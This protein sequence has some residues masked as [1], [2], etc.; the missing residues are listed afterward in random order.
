MRQTAG[1]AFEVSGC[2]GIAHR[3]TVDLVNFSLSKRAQVDI[4]LVEK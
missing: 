3:R 2:R 4:P 1:E